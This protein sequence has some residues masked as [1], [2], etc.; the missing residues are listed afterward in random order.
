MDQCCESGSGSVRS[1]SFWA[2]RIRHYFY[3]SGS[4]IIKQK[5]KKKLDFYCYVSSFWLSIFKTDKSN[6]Q[7]TFSSI[8]KATDERAG[9]GFVSH[10]YGFA[11]LDRTKLT[12][13][14][15]T[16]FT[17]CDIPVVHGTGTRSLCSLQEQDLQPVFLNFYIDINMWLCLQ[18]TVFIPS[19]RQFDNFVR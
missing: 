3:G 17:K 10:W 15:K 4:V 1:V 16:E 19:F 18:N 9:S 5:N 12:R 11:V 14:H 13:I 2:F 6:K 7:K 8:L